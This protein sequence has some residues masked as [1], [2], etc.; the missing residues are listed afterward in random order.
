MRTRQ[1]IHRKTS[2]KVSRSKTRVEIVIRV[3]EL[4]KEDDV[5]K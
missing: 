4:E 2:K 3:E 5:R 1:Q